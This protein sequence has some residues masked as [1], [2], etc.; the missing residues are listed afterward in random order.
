MDEKGFVCAR[1]DVLANGCCNAELSEQTEILSSSV[2]YLNK[3]RYT[4]E[5]CNAQGCCAVY[6]YCVSCCLDPKKVKTVYN[7]IMKR[8]S[9]FNLL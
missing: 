8:P 4:C 1:H 3:T 2:P 6:E 9:L 7:Q 5:T